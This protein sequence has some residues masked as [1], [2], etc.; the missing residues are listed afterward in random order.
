MGT[1]IG[2]ERPTTRY[3]KTGD[4]HIAYQVLGDGP[5][6]LVFVPGEWRLLAVSP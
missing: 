6:D 3:A 4:L 1:G 5:V 2:F